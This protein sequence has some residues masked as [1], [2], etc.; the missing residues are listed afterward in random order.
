MRA[1]RE[2]YSWER[3]RSRQ[4]VRQHIPRRN[5]SSKTLKSDIDF[6]LPPRSSSRSSCLNC[7]PI[8]ILGTRRASAE[9]FQRRLGL[10]PHFEYHFCKSSV[11]SHSTYTLMPDQLVFA[12]CTLIAS[13]LGETV[14]SRRCE[15]E[16]V[17]DTPIA[18]AKRVASS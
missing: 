6:A 18:Q 11:K 1:P 14:V 10:E 4:R 17:R 3:G 7:G 16:T 12:S 8:E 13:P 5:F 15:R 2:Q 9:S